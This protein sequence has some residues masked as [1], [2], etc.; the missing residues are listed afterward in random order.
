[1]DNLPRHIAI[2]M[3]GNGRWAKQRKLP[4]FAGHKKGVDTVRDITRACS[5]LGVETLTLFAFSSENWNRPKEEVSHLMQLFLWAAKREVKKLHSEN[6]RLSVIG[7]LSTVDD[8]LC[9]VIEGAAELTKNNTGLRLVIA[10][11]YGG[12]WDILQATRR[13]AERV[14]AGELEAKEIDEEVFE[15]VLSTFDLPKLDLLVRTSGECR[16][17]NF[18]IW[19]LAY[20]ELYFT[21]VY[22]PD[23]TKQELEKAIQYFSERERRFG[24]ISEQVGK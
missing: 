3:D 16:I 12:Q 10:L 19:Q 13:L 20:S 4:R 5:D 7:E 18:L 23:F 1:M 24:K 9:Q 22:W 14:K 6:V 2:I 8:K 21:D 17:S 15:S 11:N